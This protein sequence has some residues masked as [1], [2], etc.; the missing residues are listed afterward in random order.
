MKTTIWKTK[1]L[2]EKTVKC[3]QRDSL[4]EKLRPTN[5]DQIRNSGRYLNKVKYELFK[6]R[7]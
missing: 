3:T 4:Q 1:F 6:K 5:K 2:N 7:K